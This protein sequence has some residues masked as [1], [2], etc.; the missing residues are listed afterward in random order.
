MQYLLAHQENATYLAA[1]IDSTVSAPIILETGKPVMA[2]GGYAG[3]DQI[4]T[5]A[6]LKQ[7]VAAGTVH[8]FV[9]PQTFQESK[10]HLNPAVLTFQ[11]NYQALVE[12]M[13]AAS[14]STLTN[15]VRTDCTHVPTDE[16]HSS[17]E[18]TLLDVY[19]CA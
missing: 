5:L 16:W 11:E 3:S 9:L 19:D 14:T 7:L 13:G 6:H 12:A 2:M 18:V 1:T 10:A 17:S 8:Y 4:L 15:W